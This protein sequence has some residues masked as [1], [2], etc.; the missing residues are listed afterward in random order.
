M[1][2]IFPAT[3]ESL[4]DFQYSSLASN[5]SMVHLHLLFRLTS[6]HMGIPRSLKIYPSFIT[7]HPCCLSQ[8]REGGIKVLIP[9]FWWFM[10]DLE[11][12]TKNHKQFQKVLCGFFIRNQH[13][14]IIN[15]KQL[16]EHLLI[17]SWELESSHC[18][19]AHSISDT[20]GQPIY[21]NSIQYKARVR[22][23]P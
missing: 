8:S 4:C 10:L 5:I 7:L 18:A 9:I 1:I 14:G 20:I 3:R 12:G 11:F 2:I 21:C 19:F 13:I 17:S 16:Q 15:N 22:G 6:N 23:H